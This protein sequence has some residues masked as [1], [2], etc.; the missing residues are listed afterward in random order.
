MNFHN[1]S[2]DLPIMGLSHQTSMT[3]YPSKF[4]PLKSLNEEVWEIRLSHNQTF[5]DRLNGVN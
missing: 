5:G 2:N 3:A 1:N 4:K